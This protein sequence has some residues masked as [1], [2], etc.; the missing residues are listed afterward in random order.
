MIIIVH[1]QEY[2]IKVVIV[3]ILEYRMHVCNSERDQGIPALACLS[4]DKDLDQLANSQADQRLCR[5][6]SRNNKTIL[7]SILIQASL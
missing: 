3:T 2:R 1:I 6:L 4:N 5:S 7:N